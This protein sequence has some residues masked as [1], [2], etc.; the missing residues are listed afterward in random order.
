MFSVL[1]F[2]GESLYQNSGS[3]VIITNQSLVLQRIDR[4]R[5]GG[6]TCQASNLVGRG[7]SQEI[8]LDVKCKCILLNLISQKNLDFFQTVLRA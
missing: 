5:S 1:F 7:S 4:T 3:G 2:Q 6:Y 8:F